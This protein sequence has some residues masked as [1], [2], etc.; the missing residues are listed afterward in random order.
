[1]DDLQKLLE[2]A[3]VNEMTTTDFDRAFDNFERA[4]ETMYIE[5]RDIDNNMADNFQEVGGELWR[6][7]YAEKGKL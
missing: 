3:G 7:L 1:M 5:L 4:Y 6:F 2:N